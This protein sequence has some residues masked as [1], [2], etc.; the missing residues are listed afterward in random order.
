MDK[1]IEGKLKSILGSLYNKGYADSVRV[2]ECDL[3]YKKQGDSFDKH[4]S[5][6]LREIIKIIEEK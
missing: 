2:R 5:F 6:A 4:T 3:S 1:N